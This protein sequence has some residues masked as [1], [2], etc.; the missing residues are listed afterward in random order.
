MMRQVLITFVIFPR[1]LALLNV[2]YALVQKD[3]VCLVTLKL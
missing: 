3:Y 2:R 1:N